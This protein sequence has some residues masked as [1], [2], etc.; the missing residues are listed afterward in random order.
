M[1]TAEFPSN[2]SKTENTVKWFSWSQRRKHIY[3]SK[4][5]KLFLALESRS[6]PLH[7]GN[8]PLYIG[9]ASSV[10]SGTSVELS[11]SM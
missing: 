2:Q 9:Q 1:S 11:E 8:R 10:V 7:M 5:T 6:L 3:L 4:E